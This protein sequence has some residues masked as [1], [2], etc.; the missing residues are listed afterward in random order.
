MLRSRILI[1]LVSSALLSLQMVDVS[2]I[3]SNGHA[4]VYPVVIAAI[5]VIRL[6]ARRVSWLRNFI[7][8]VLVALKKNKPCFSATSR[9]FSGIA[10]FKGFSKS[11]NMDT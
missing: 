3:R 1:G 4:P 9:K 7:Y 8:Y 6:V 2:Y 11:A 5:R 10:N